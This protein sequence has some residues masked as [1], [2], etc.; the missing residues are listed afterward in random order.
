MMKSNKNIIVGE[1][2]NF[3]KIVESDLEVLI[4]W[5]N[6]KKMYRYNNQFVLLNMFLQEK[7]FE[8]INKNK[9]NRIMFLV[10]NKK[11]KPIGVCG[12]IHVDKVNKS[13]DC[14]ILLGDQKIHGKGLGSEILDKLVDYGFTHL[15][16]HR[17]GAEIFSYN[18]ISS[19]LFKKLGFKYEVT[20]REA[21]WRD[22]K[23]WD[24]DLYS[25][26]KQERILQNIKK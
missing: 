15:G 9:S 3:R 25:L 17:I 14:A 7:W 26:L 6:S 13:G 24:I 16:L 23:W 5:R 20:F 19:G 18:K 11:N 12:L 4:K 2:V 8:S 21:L 22:N 10:T 1:K